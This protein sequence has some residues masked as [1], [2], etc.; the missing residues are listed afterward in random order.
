MDA[1]GVEQNGAT[2]PTGVVYRPSEALLAGG[3]RTAQGDA[4]NPLRGYVSAQGGTFGDPTANDPNSP[5]YDPNRAL[6]MGATGNDPAGISNALKSGNQEAIAHAVRNLTGQMSTSSG[7]GKLFDS[8]TAGGYNNSS[9]AGLP[10]ATKAQIAA[11]ITGRSDYAANKAAYD[12]QIIDLGL[13]P[14]KMSANAQQAGTERNP[15]Y[16]QAQKAGFAVGG[17]GKVYDHGSLVGDINDPNFKMP[18]GSWQTADNGYKADGT[19]TPE[20]QAQADALKKQREAGGPP[21]KDMRHFDPNDVQATDTGK[22]DAATGNFDVVDY[23]KKQLAAPT[24]YDDPTSMALFKR[25]SEDIQDKF[26]VQ[27]RGLKDW[28]MSHGLGESSIYGGNQRSLNVDRRSAM[29]DLNA[30]TMKQRAA[31]TQQGQMG[32]LDRLTGA[33]N[34]AFNQDLQTQ[35]QNTTQQELYLKQLQAMLGA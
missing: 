24:P 12:Q 1:N 21:P 4:S 32:W 18:K 10:D 30:E 31:S 27:D 29:E 22:G 16:A 19:F 15:L 13:K 7:A 2:P 11:G 34:T 9:F 26:D 23:L 5:T 20:A 6:D 14:G 17:D 25:Q 8:G 3:T 28:A 33:G 35:Q